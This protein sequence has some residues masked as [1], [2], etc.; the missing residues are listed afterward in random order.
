MV[1]GISFLDRFLPCISKQLIELFEPGRSRPLIP[2]STS[3]LDSP[4]D[5]C[6]DF[7]AIEALCEESLPQGREHFIELL[8][9]G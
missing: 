2:R 6:I 1:V 8:L 5:Q 4:V 9:P 3:L 7:I